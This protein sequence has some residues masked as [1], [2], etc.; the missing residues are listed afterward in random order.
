MCKLPLIQRV[1]GQK[2]YIFIIISL[3]IAINVHADSKQTSQE[4]VGTWK[5]APQS[6]GGSTSQCVTKFSQNGT[7]TE[8]IEKYPSGEMELFITG[9]WKVKESMITFETLT[10]SL[11]YIE[12]PGDLSSYKIQQ[13][14]NNRINLTNE[15]GYLRKLKKVE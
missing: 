6:I 8:W 12:A 1:L 7:Y 15:Y 2:K 4:L 10:S 9:I 13:L 11:P 5:Q 3:L 14:N